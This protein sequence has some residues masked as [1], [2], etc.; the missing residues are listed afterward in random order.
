M[1]G[2][3]RVSGE[4][5]LPTPGPA[6]VLKKEEIHVLYLLSEEEGAGYLKEFSEHDFTDPQAAR[7]FQVLQETR[8]DHP[9]GACF[10]AFVMRLE[11]SNLK[12]KVIELSF[13]E[14]NQEERAKALQDCL[15]KIERLRFEAERT[16]LEAKI[17][18]AE[19]K[20]ELDRLTEYLKDFQTLNSMSAKGK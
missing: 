18:S 4:V 16:A 11:E 10:S 1:K 7:A 20:G 17:R 8:R 2:S 15:R 19:E 14:W 13:L 9:A 5:S 12:R 3:P 6:A